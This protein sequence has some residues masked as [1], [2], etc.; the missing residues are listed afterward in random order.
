MIRK[1]INNNTAD[2]Y[3]LRAYSKCL[4]CINVFSLPNKARSYHPSFTAE[5]TE[6]ERSKGDTAGASRWTPRQPA[7]FTPQPLWAFGFPVL[8]EP[9]VHLRCYLF[10]RLVWVRGTPPAWTLNCFRHTAQCS[11]E[12]GLCGCLVDQLVVKRADIFVGPW[13]VML[14]II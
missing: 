1:T 4:T 12:L 10:S 6:A 2:F 3:C 13:R 11:E 9:A 14:I 8:P 5:E 7:V